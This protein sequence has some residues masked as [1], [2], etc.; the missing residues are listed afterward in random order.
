[1]EVHVYMFLCKYG[2]FSDDGYEYVITNPK[3]PKPW[4]NVISNGNYSIL[5]T[6]TGGGYSWGKN[7]IEN[8]ITRFVQDSVKDDFGKYIYIRDDDTGEIWGTTY[9][10]TEKCGDDYKVIHGLGYS[11]FI[12]TYNEIE[13]N[14]KVFLSKDDKMEFFYI[15]LKNK[16]KRFRR[17]SVFF[18]AELY[19]S[20]FPEENREFDKLFMETD[21]D[22]NLNVLIGKKSF[23]SVI[24][25]NGNC[26][27]REYKYLFFMGSTEKIIS[28]ETS[29]EKF[30]GMYNSFKNPESLKNILLSNTVGKNLDAIS[31]IH[32]RIELNSYE[33]KNFSF[34]MGICE[35]YDEVLNISNKYKNISNVDEE[36]IRF[37][38]FVREFID[39][40]K[41]NTPDIGINFMTNIWCKY[42][43]I[44]CRFFSKASYYQNNKGIGY[45]DHLQDSLIFLTSKEDIIRNQ[46]LYQASMQFKNGKVVHFFLDESKFFIETNSS[47]DNLWLVYI[48]LIYIKE[49]NDIDILD[50]KVKYID[51][52]EEEELYFHLKNSIE[53][54][55]GNISSRGLSFMLNHDWND[56]ISNFNG[57]SIF[58]SEF[59]YLVLKEFIEICEIKNDYDFLKKIENYMR[60]IKNGVNNFGFYKSW[61]LRGVSDDITLGSVDCEYGKIFLLPQAFAIISGIIDDENKIKVMDEVYKHLN[62]KYGL[63]ILTPPYSKT[64][65]KIGYITRYAEGTRENG[66]IYYHSCMWGILAFIMVNKIDIAKE[67]IHNILPPNKSKEIDLYKIEPYV[68]PSSVDGDYSKNFGMGNWSFNTGSSVWFHRII[69]NFII[70]VRGTLKGLLIDPKPFSLWKKFSIS[71]KYR[72]A[73]F[74]IKFE[75]NNGRNLEIFVDGYKIEGNLITNVESGRVYNVKVVIK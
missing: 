51:F 46:I 69:T 60:I 66:S 15:I 65:K 61:Y 63:K 68:M 37:K 28:Y 5:I 64:N 67:I 70:G 43:T 27:N 10:P 7:S 59:L 57:E 22:E 73:R 8:R 45:R 38:N 48:S 39:D 71:R 33:S 35:S 21:F 56:A 16:S 31:C 19:L 41:I 4:S 30:I 3:T 58:V 32:N 54:S 26:N 52:N 29:R 20:N 74:N 75:N 9:K 42:Q 13:S 14:L 47:D 25:K 1:M 23:W 53:Y 72:N 11:I 18:C 36:F 44:M 50:C 17:L 62:T 12:H 24:D 49:S 34:Y 40:E 2:Y 55:L 6:Q